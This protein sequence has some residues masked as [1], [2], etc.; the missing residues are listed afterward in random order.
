MTNFLAAPNSVN[1]L[2][3]VNH[4]FFCAMV[5]INVFAALQMLEYFLLYTHD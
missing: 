2:L 5:N 1:V 4:F 3:D